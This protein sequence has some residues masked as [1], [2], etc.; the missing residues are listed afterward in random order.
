[1]TLPSAACIGPD[2]NTYIFNTGS[3]GHG[4]CSGG[5]C[6]GSIFGGNN[7]WK[8]VGIGA[9]ITAGIG[10]LDWIFSPQ[11]KF[12]GWFSSAGNWSSGL[13]FSGWGSGLDF[14]GWGANL[15]GW[16]GG[17]DQAFAASPLGGL[18][19]GLEQTK[20]ENEEYKKTAKKYETVINAALEAADLKDVSKDV[21]S[22]FY[23]DLVNKCE[24]IKAAKSDITDADLQN[25][26]ENFARARNHDSELVENFGGTDKT[27]MTVC[28][29]DNIKE[30]YNKIGQGYVELFD[31]N[32]DGKVDVHEFVEYE[33]Q[34]AK[35]TSD[36]EDAK[37]AATTM[38]AVI[39]TN[40]DNQLDAKELAAYNYLTAT[41]ADEEGSIATAEE[42]STDDFEQFGEAAEALVG[43]TAKQAEMQAKLKKAADA[44]T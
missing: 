43:D 14:S 18:A 27:D 21:M 36:Y 26:I 31:A 42:I 20:K 7:F 12:D 2:R 8:S 9:A 23:R 4:H 22:Q 35:G 17:Y 25:R 34:V 32:T 33:S 41:Y 30:A 3:Y 37:E 15:S 16:F 10:L 5:Y 13:D 1:M 24:A 28:E 6:G 11:Q 38:F 19:L 40:N 39:D 29:A 44:L